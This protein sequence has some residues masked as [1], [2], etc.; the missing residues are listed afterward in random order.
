MINHRFIERNTIVDFEDDWYVIKLDEHRYYKRVSGYGLKAVD[1]VATHP[2]IGVFLIELKD[3]EKGRESIP[4]NIDLV[5]IEKQE[6]TLKLMRII[7]KYYQRQFI[8]RLMRWINND[9]LYPKDWRF[10]IYTFDHIKKGNYQFIGDI[11]Y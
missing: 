11:S 9:K 7:E 4:E 8:Y 5:M 6:D 2:K 1:F 3:Y 10:W